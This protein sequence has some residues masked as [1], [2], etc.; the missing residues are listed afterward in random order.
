MA[1]DPTTQTLTMTSTITTEI[2]DNRKFTG[3]FGTVTMTTGPLL[4]GSVYCRANELPVL[5][6][7]MF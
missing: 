5:W 7:L 2:F 3:N 1:F 4:S 6:E